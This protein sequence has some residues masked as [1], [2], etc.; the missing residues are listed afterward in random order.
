MN[1]KAPRGQAA[2]R[3][4]PEERGPVDAAAALDG[5]HRCGPAVEPRGRQRGPG[6]GRFGLRRQDPH[7]QVRG[8]ERLQRRLQVAGQRG[9]ARHEDRAPLGLPLAAGERQR[10]YP[11]GSHKDKGAAFGHEARHDRLEEAQRQHEGR[12]QRP[13]AVDHLAPGGKDDGRRR[14]A[15]AQHPVVKGR[16]LGRGRVEAAH[17]VAQVVAG[18]LLDAAGQLD[19]GDGKVRA[20]HEHGAARAAAR[21]GAVEV[22]GLPV[23][24]GV[25]DLA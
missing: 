11:L 6:P 22:V 4:G 23:L 8:L 1:T 2:P 25:A 18:V 15:R 9:G 10:L 21:L 13:V 17:A 12:L 7:G 3:R 14:A 16:L 24:P 5:V 20:L 19:K